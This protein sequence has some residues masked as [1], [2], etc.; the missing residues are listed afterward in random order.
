MKVSIPVMECTGMSAPVGQ[1]FGRVPAF[2]VIDVESGEIEFIRN[3][4][5]HLGGIGLPPELL[6][7]EGVNVVLCSA[8]G[9]KAVDLCAS[10]GMQVFVGARGT[11]SES[12]EAW[13]QGAL[14]R[15]DR[16]NACAEHSH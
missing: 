9:P 5:E 8:L 11:V 13:K 6:A 1:H 12:L 3:T 10:L 4:S 15:A 16:D 14:T 7:K 2:A